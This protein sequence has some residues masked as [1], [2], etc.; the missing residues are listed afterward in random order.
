MHVPPSVD[1]VLLLL[2]IFHAMND[3]SGENNTFNMGLT[4]KQLCNITKAPYYVIK[5]LNS[6]GRLPIV[7]ESRG[8]GYPTT[9][10]DDAVE[11]VRRHMLKSGAAQPV[12][13]TP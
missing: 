2:L 9:F 11:I 4:L 10:H 3:V 8:R 12:Q 13:D 6:L 7:Q 1:F 5:Y